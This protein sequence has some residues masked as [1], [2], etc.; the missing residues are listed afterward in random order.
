MDQEEEEEEEEQEEEEEEEAEEEEQ[1]EEEQEREEE[2]EA[3]EE[4]AEEEE[5][6][7]AGEEEEAAT[8]GHLPAPLTVTLLSR[9]F[10]L[11]HPSPLLMPFPPLP[12]F[13]FPLPSIFRGKPWCDGSVSL[14]M[15]LSTLFSLPPPL[16]P[17]PSAALY[18]LKARTLCTPRRRPP[19]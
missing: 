10:I 15:R 9:P 3:E 4:Q 17:C 5:E 14:I 8:V 12:C 11:P 18:L 2:E 7:E 19:Q 1:E 6:Q 16:A 13:L